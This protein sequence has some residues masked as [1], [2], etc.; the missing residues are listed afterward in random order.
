[1]HAVPQRE[2]LRQLADVEIAAQRLLG[3]GI[4]AREAE[5]FELRRVASDP[6]LSAGSRAEAIDRMVTS[7]AEG[8]QLQRA[9]A[10]ASAINR[11]LLQ[12]ASASSSAELEILKFPV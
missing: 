10:E 7:I 2:L 5:V 11:A 8:P 4:L 6:N 3:P 12:A 9:R 1:M